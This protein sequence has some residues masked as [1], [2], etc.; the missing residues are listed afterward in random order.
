PWPAPG[1]WGYAWP[2]PLVLGGAVLLLVGLVLALQAFL[3]LGWA[4]G[5]G[6]AGS[7]GL[8]AA[9]WGLFTAL[10]SRARED[11]E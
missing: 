8:I 6:W 7:L 4:L 2:L 9:G 5:P 11:G 3:G 1:S 10:A